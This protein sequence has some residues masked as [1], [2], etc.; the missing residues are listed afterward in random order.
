[1]WEVLTEADSIQQGSDEL[2]DEY[3]VD[4]ERLERDLQGFVSQLLE[5]R[6]AEV[7]DG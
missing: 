4:R 5:H 6:L 1:M 2:C 3:E 7:S